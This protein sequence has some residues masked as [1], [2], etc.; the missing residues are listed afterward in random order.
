MRVRI[1]GHAQQATDF[2]LAPPVGLSLVA[3]DD[4][5]PIARRRSVRRARANLDPT[6][7][8]LDAGDL[9]RLTIRTL[10]LG[11]KRQALVGFLVLC[12]S[13]PCE[14]TVTLRQAVAS[15]RRRSLSG[16]FGTFF[17]PRLIRDF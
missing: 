10:L 3:R 13:L 4:A 8:G 5:A 17:L 14:R 2:R 1:A 11:R 12:F 6:T 9:G 7:V 16:A 15:S